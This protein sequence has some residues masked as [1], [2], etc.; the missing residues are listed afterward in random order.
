M[1]FAQYEGSALRGLPVASSGPK[2][3]GMCTSICSLM[4]AQAAGV[5]IQELE[6]ALA[7]CRDRAASLGEGCGACWW[8]VDEAQ[9]RRALRVSSN[10]GTLLQHEVKV[11][12]S[13]RVELRAGC[14]AQAETQRIRSGYAAGTWA[15][16]GL[17]LFIIFMTVLGAW[18]C[19]HEMKDEACAP[20]CRSH[21]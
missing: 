11:P 5:W 20:P 6:S 21:L 1:Q 18:G 17:A 2:Q 15:V 4:Q 13:A 19:I 14:V 16:L 3:R 12:L 10:L 9:V 8:L 7:K